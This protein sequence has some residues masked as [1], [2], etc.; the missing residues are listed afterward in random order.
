[1]AC[2]HVRVSDGAARSC[3]KLSEPV[4]SLRETNSPHE[5]TSASTPADI[6]LGTQFGRG[7]S[8]LY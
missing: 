2:E 3:C 8:F 5:A 4:I 1:M 7:A 6:I